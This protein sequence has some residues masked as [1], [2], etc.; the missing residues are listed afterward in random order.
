MAGETWGTVAATTDLE[1]SDR[2]VNPFAAVIREYQKRV[3][4][5]VRRGRT[6]AALR[7]AGLIVKLERL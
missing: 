4:K 1:E 5:A 3:D 7:W 6:K 2:T